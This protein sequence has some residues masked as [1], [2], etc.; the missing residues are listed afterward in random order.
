MDY[1][2]LPPPPPFDQ[3]VHRFWFL[4][5]NGGAEPQTIVPDGRVEIVFHLGEPFAQL[6]ETGRPTPQPRAIAA[7]QLTGPL[8]L[9]PR[10][11]AEVVGIRLCTGAARRFLRVPQHELTGRILPLRDLARGLEPQVLDALRP[12][13]DLPTR[14]ER[15]IGVLGHHLADQGPSP[16]DAAVACL[17]SGRLQTVAELASAVGLTPRTLQRRFLE[18][19]GMEPTL[20]RRILRFR[21]AFSLLERLPPGRWSR[22]APRTGYFDQAH[23]IREFRRFAGAPPSVFFGAGPELARAFSSSPAAE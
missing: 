16:I 7:G 17:E 18:E 2:E 14:L 4:R 10:P 20:L 12:P 3:L 8:R 19:V 1:L 6:D 5:G 11:G 23:L 9:L 22:V 21:T 13:A 15:L